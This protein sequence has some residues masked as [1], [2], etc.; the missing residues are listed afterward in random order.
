M[1]Q[2]RRDF[3]KIINRSADL[4][5]YK[6]S[7]KTL[8]QFLYNHTKQKVVLLIDEYDTTIHEAYERG[9][10]NNIVNFLRAFLGPGLKDN[11]CIERYVIT[12]ILRISKESIFSD[13]NNFAVFTALND[14]YSDI[15]CIT[16][17][18]VWDALETYGLESYKEVVK[19]WYNGDIFGSTDG[20]YNPWSVLNFLVSDKEGLRPHWVNTIF[21]NSV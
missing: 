15:F 3:E 18:E 7:L 2:N 4:S 10:Y 21:L 20:M 9:Y 13:L 6:N 19:D 8:T 11:P 17:K 16:E 12:G 1:G 14:K 5:L